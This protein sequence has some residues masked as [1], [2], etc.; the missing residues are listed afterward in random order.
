L[1]LINP[2]LHKTTKNRWMTNQHKKCQIYE[3]LN[4][5]SFIMTVKITEL[6]TPRKDETLFYIRYPHTQVPPSFS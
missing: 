5:D 4:R 2:R 6:A 3:T 1:D